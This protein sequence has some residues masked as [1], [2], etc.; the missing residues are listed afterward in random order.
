MFETKPFLSRPI[1][2]QPSLRKGDEAA[3]ATNMAL[4]A[5]RAA[6]RRGSFGKVWGLV[7]GRKPGLLD[8]NA[9]EKKIRMRGRRYAGLPAVL[10]AKISGTLGRES[11]FDAAFNPRRETVRDR[12]L[13]VARARLMGVPLPPVE[14]IQVGERY[15]VRD[16][17]HRI[18]VAS[19]FG[20]E[21][22][23]AEV[24]VWDVE[25]SLPWEKTVERQSLASQTA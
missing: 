12:W 11:D 6:L 24:I 7:S 22:I 25:G 20:E 10:I 2:S 18:S 14:L 15:F 19:A 21:A 17:H 1:V 16:G 5:F 9:V 23:D 4:S 3:Q 8:L 13:S